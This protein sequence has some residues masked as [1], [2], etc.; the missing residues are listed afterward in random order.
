MDPTMLFGHPDTEYFW[1]GVANDQ[2]VLRRCAGC[3]VIQ[4]P[5]QGTPICGVCHESD[6]DEVTASGRGTV[7]TWIESRH[8]SRADGVPPR[9]AAVIQLEEG[10]RLVSNIIG[11]DP[12]QVRNDAPVR[13]CFAEVN[14][15]RLPQFRLVEGESGEGV[16]S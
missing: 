12:G 13:V 6:F 5:P 16:P 4:D 2:L 14:G 7:Y 10:V 9:I 11:A 15:M 1:K 8:P 3:G